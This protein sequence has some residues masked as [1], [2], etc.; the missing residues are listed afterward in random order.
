MHTGKGKLWKDEQVQTFQIVC[1]GLAQDGIGTV[2]VIVDI[3]NLGR[4]LQAGNLHGV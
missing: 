4:K 2:Q 3:A 1:T